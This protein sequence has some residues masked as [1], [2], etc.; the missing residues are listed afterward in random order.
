MGALIVL[1]ILLAL[2]ASAQAGP[3]T[4]PLLV[5][6]SYVADAAEDTCPKAQAI[7]STSATID[8]IN[9]AAARLNMTESERT[10]L[11]AFCSLYIQGHTAGLT[12]H[13]R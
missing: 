5:R 8:M 10:L 6:V 12:E 11:T 3:N 2:A 1:T 13:G 4:E 7:R 9:G